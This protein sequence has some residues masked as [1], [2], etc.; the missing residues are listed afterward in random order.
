MSPR[1]VLSAGAP[2]RLGDLRP[3]VVVARGSRV[4]MQ[5][6]YG[7]LTV[8][9]GGRAL[10]DGAMGAVIRVVNVDSSRTVEAVVTGPNQ[11][12]VDPAAAAAAAN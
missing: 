5:V 2:V 12:A 3:P 8:T 11:V 6:R 1:R 9:A 10:E 7:A 4:T